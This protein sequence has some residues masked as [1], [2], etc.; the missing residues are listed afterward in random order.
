M[1]EKTSTEQLLKKLRIRFYA[2]A[3]I[4]TTEYSNG[5]RLV[6][7]KSETF[8]IKIDDVPEGAFFNGRI[9][10][11]V[12]HLAEK[13]IIDTIDLKYHP[14]GTLKSWKLY[15]DREMKNPISTYDR[16]I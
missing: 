1:M 6:L 11:F 14:H 4:S 5:A 8:D 16:I 10:P 9:P 2:I 12:I 15:S 13:K 7:I 3:E